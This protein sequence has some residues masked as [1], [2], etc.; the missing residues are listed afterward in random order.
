MTRYNNEM[1]LF[2]GLLCNQIQAFSGCLLLVRIGC[3]VVKLKFEGA[4][5]QIL[6]QLLFSEVISVYTEELNLLRAF[7]SKLQIRQVSL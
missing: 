1:L 6:F 7:I 4:T 3:C 2:V 5:C